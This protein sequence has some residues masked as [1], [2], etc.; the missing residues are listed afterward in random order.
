MPQELATADDRQL[1]QDMGEFWSNPLGY[2]EYAF[3]WGE[4]ELE[5]FLGPDTWQ[6]EYLEDLGKQVAQRGFD[7]VHPVLPV[8]MA[9]ASGHG[10]GKA[11]PNDLVLFTPAGWRAWGSLKPSEEVFGLDGCPTP[12]V[13]VHERGE[14]E[15]Y[16]VRFDDGSETLVCADH[17]WTVRG[18][19]QRRKGLGWVERSTLELLEQGV[20]RPNGKAQ[21]RQ[22]QVPLHGA[23]ELP[24]CEVPVHPYTLG[25]WLGD[26]GR[27]SARITTAD[28]GVIEA[29]RR[30]GESLHLGSKQGTEALSVTVHGLGPKLRTL[31]VFDCYSYEKWIP[32]S[33]LENHVEV[34]SR[35]LRG[36]LDSDGEVARHG[37]VIYNS[38]S[39]RLAEQVVWLARSLGAK[40][41]IQPTTKQPTYPGPHGKLLAGRPC[42]RV[43]L[44]FPPGFQ[45]FEIKR[46]QARIPSR[47]APRYRCRWLDS[48]ELV[49]S[50]QVSCI[51][52]EAKDGIYLTQDFL[53]T[54]NSALTAWIILWVLS[55]RPMSKGVVTANTATQLETKT[56]AELS[57]WKNRAINGK[58]FEVRTG[59][60]SMRI[61]HKLHPEIWRC[62]AQTCREENSEAFAG[63]HA[64]SSTPFYI[65]DEASA[66]PDKIWEVAEGGL[67]DGEPMMLVFGNPT[68]HDGTFFEIF[69]KLRHRWIRRQIDSRDV[70]FPN[71][72][73][74]QQWIDDYG[75]DS[76]FVRVRV[77][78]TF[79]RA[80]AMQ[81]IDTETVA[82]ARTREAA[83]LIED[84]LIAGLDLARG[85]EAL[86][87]I[88]F[89]RG[90]C[91]RHTAES[92]PATIVIPGEQTR[93]SMRLV[94]KVMDVARRFKP[95]VWFVDGTGMGGPI[96]DRLRQLNLMV[97]E[98]NFGSAAPDPHYANRRAYM[99]GQMREWLYH[100]G[101]IDDL[102]D[103]ATDLSAPQYGHNRRDQL[104]LES[105]EAMEKR[106]IASPDRG[107]ALALTFA[108]PV[109]PKGLAQL[110]QVGDHEWDPFAR[111]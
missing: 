68:R 66:V 44:T 79:P 1:A 76:D 27:R 43:T 16:R 8:R 103:L 36:L 11:Q 73:Q 4:G 80:S 111:P 85:G 87:V 25:L 28:L 75:E 63:L 5:G 30:H 86:N 60:G 41:R 106:G 57:K 107:D 17:V 61:F 69:H 39:Q 109:L 46:K 62:D 108:T 9:T 90:M 96:C 101:A 71:K 42:H 92:V 15:V 13:A 24:E 94:S 58:W 37:S 33:Y 95:D 14:R 70:R 72:I 97:E 74:I 38:T 100:G 98:V 21:A 83:F 104:L 55:T 93:D 31:G 45:A 91:A 84:P 6:A 89:R 29:L 32:E 20:K 47:V 48:I 54:H 23:I 102:E 12:I 18:R 110:E 22:W 19:Q 77:K 82:E 52:V 67:T 65:F 40:A 51:T 50:S 35:L 88:Q 59:R 81:F 53:P 64:V 99:W 7:G 56:W 105:K 49:G 34:R 2:V 3:P 78:G 10:I 26:G